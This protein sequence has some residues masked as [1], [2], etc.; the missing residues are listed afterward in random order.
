MNTMGGLIAQVVDLPFSG[1]AFI[2]IAKRRKLA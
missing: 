2:K 1:D